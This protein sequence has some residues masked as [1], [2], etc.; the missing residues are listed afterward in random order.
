MNKL[1]GSFLLLGVVGVLCGCVPDTNGDFSAVAKQASSKLGFDVTSVHLSQED[2]QAYTRSIIEKPI[3][4]ESSV[5]IAIFNNKTLR[6]KVEDLW[7]AKADYDLNSALP[8]PAFSGSIQFQNQGGGSKTELSVEQDVMGFFIL[9]LNAKANDAKFESTKLE[10]SQAVLDLAFNVKVAYYTVL[11]SQESLLT[12]QKIADASEASFELTRRQFKAGNIPEIQLKNEQIFYNQAKLD[13][14]ESL[15]ELAVSRERFSHLMGIGKTSFVLDSQTL[16]RLPESDPNG[17]LLENMALEQRL[18]LAML[19]ATLMAQ[20]QSLPVAGLSTLKESKVGLKAEADPDGK[21]SL[22]PSLSFP[23]PISNAGQAAVSKQEAMVRQARHQVDAKEEEIRSDVRL[24]LEH[25][26]AARKRVL[27]LQNDLLPLQQRVID[28]T[29]QQYNYMLVGV[30]TL[31]QAKQ[32]EI[33]MHDTYIK[34]RQGY[35]TARA[36]LEKAVGTKLST[37]T[38][39]NPTALPQPIKPVLTP[40][41]SNHY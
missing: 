7:I 26:A 24:A 29:L 36:E 16:P 19:K 33:H 6:A 40:A 30:F 9:P 34:A 25:L 14:A 37:Q 13:L 17:E 23:I 12:K 15:S 31:L 3:G 38:R 4:I 27:S 28:L 2:L 20:S 22:G 1:M 32:S 11:A 35:W 18:D 10:V 5:K 8:N 41:H 39:T 21:Q